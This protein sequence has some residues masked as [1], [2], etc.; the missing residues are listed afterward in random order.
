M[1]VIELWWKKTSFPSAPRMNPNPRSLISRLILPVGI[2]SLLL[3]P[4]STLPGGGKGS[5]AGR[6]IDSL[7]ASKVGV[8]H[9]VK[10]ARIIIRAQ[11]AVKEAASGSRA[12][13]YLVSFRG[14]GREE[15]QIPRF[16]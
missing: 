14:Q 16:T 9:R 6:R 10:V 1:S 4:N 2:A 15:H 11:S 7:S 12:R 8:V 5:E 3:A 13:F